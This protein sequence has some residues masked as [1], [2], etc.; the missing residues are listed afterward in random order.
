MGTSQAQMSSR[1]PRQ[2]RPRSKTNPSGLRRAGARGRG[3]RGRGAADAGRRRRR[4]GVGGWGVPSPAL[5]LSLPPAE[6]ALGAGRVRQSFKNKE[7]PA[8]SPRRLW[9]T[10]RPAPTAARSPAAWVGV[11]QAARG[12]VG[13]GWLAPQPVLQRRLTLLRRLEGLPPVRGRPVPAGMRSARLSTHT[14]WAC[15]GSAAQASYGHLFVKRCTHTFVC[16]NTY[17]CQ[18][19]T[20]KD[21]LSVIRDFQNVIRSTGSVEK[22]HKKRFLILNTKL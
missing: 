4:R 1:G 11:G 20:C 15:A 9:G 5:L 6:E 7:R 13:A 19:R 8:G 18:K 10:G 14:R 21:A 22:T 3:P 2:R 17:V 12:P 16:I